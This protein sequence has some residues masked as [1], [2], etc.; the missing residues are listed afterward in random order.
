MFR[1]ADRPRWHVSTSIPK[2]CGGIRRHRSSF[3]CSAKALNGRWYMV[4]THLSA[5]LAFT[6]ILL[7]VSRPQPYWA[8]QLW[9]LWLIIFRQSQKQTGPQLL[10]IEQLLLKP[11]ITSVRDSKCP[12]HS[13][14]GKWPMKSIHLAICL[15]EE[16]CL[17]DKWDL[18]GWE[19]TGLRFRAEWRSAGF[20]LSERI[21]TA[22]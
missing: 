15:C 20:W 22:V 1:T 13:L 10:N 9:P 7:Y 2:T 6:V 16:S 4:G 21:L 17:E 11:L 14:V 3:Y 19:R 18:A 12:H 5:S 8:V